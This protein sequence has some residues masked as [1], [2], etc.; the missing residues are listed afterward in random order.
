MLV[1]SDDESKVYLNGTEI[2]KWAT[3]RAYYACELRMWFP[4]LT[5]NANSGVN[6]LVFKVINEL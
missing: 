3:G 5:P 4:G 6:T 2:Y 1:V